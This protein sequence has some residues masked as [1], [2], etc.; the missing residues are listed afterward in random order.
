MNKL[1]T[2]FYSYVIMRYVNQNKHKEGYYMRFDAKSYER[3]FPRV[4]EEEVVESA[5]ETFKKPET[6]EESENTVEE[7][8]GESELA[9]GSDDNS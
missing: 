2:N 7:A 9:D 3:L 8:E 5:I 4:P 6:K 1:L